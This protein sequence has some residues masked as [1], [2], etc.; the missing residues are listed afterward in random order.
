MPWSAITIT[1]VSSYAT[2][3]AEHGEESPDLTVDISGRQQVAF[4]CLVD[5]ELVVAPD[6]T[7]PRYSG[8]AG[9]RRRPGREFQDGEGRGG[10]RDGATRSRRCEFMEEVVEGRLLLLPEFV[11]ILFRSR[12]SNPST[13][14][15]AKG[16]RMWHRR[17]ARRGR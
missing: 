7:L 10:G 5:D 9:Y 11:G 16:V 12:V 14:Q 2:V 13:S 15:R 4:V 1:S 3:P 17:A 8:V 6:R